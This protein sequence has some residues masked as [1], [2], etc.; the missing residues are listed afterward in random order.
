MNLPIHTK[1]KDTPRLNPR[2]KPSA[3]N[4]KSSVFPEECVRQRREAIASPGDFRTRRAHLF[5]LLRLFFFEDFK[6]QQ[7]QQ[8]KQ[9]NPNC[10]LGSAGF[11]APRDG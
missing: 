8:Q 11:R 2:Q 3:S 7:Q 4:E 1:P 6:Q 5:L 10:F 9:Q